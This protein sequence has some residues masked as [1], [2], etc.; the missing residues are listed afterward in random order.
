MIPSS[1]RAALL[2]SLLLAAPAS[3]SSIGWKVQ[4]GDD[5]GWASP[6]FDDSKWRT[7]PLPALW[8]EQGLEDLDG[9]VWFRQTLPLDEEARLAAAR[10]DLGLLLGAP[11]AGGY[12]VYAGGRLLGRSRGWSSQLPFAAP[13]VFRVPREAIGKGGTLSLALRVRRIDWASDLEPDAGP[14]SDILQLGFHQALQDRTRVAWT[15]AL[16]SELPLLILAALFA[17]TALYHLLLFPRRRRTG[18]LLFGLLSLIYSVNTFASTWWIYEVTA[19]RGIAVR[20]SDLTGHLAAALAIQFL[21]RFFARPIHPPLRAYQLSHVALAAFIGLWPSVRPVVTSATF[22]LLWLLPLLVMAVTL[23]LRD[24]WRGGPEARKIAGGGLAMIGIQGL[25]LARQVIPLP[26]P[27]SLAGFGF[28][29]V[30]VAM[31]LAISERFRRVHAELDRL[32]LRLEEQV[33]DRTRALE[34]AM[35]QALAASRAK[36]EFLANISHEIRTPL[37]GVIGMADLLNGT[38]LDPRQKEYV[39]TLLVSGEA[40]VELINDVLDLSRIESRELTVERAPFVLEKVLGESLEIIGPMAARKGLSLRSS[41][42]EG[43]P[44]TVIGDQGRTRQVLLNLLSNAV[45][46]TQQGEVRV[47]LSAHPLDDGRCEVRFAVTDTGIGITERDLDRLFIPFQQLDGSPSRRY[48]GAGLG[49]AISKKLSELMGGEIRV[50]S[51]PGKG[52]TFLFTL[53][54]KTA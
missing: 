52:S 2:A 20:M 5:P 13:E 42:A 12:E 27:I 14:V 53:P 45:K 39:Q 26:I 46:F 23:I 31:S 38:A 18:H 22:R 32:R 25:E 43:T 34:Q 21:W 6:G 9:P 41:I 40:L 51:A 3:A 17:A 7:V 10:D 24:A 30:L 4:A 49:L 33:R 44:E 1:L 28:A 29:A 19:S 47:A 54:A 35:E 11:S 8:K 16:L 15:R 48:G 50:E 36:S 37:N